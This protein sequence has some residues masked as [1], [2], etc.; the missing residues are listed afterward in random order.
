[1]KLLT[2]PKITEENDDEGNND[3]IDMANELRE[4][5]AKIR[6]ISKK[7]CTEDQQLLLDK[8]SIKDD[9]NK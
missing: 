3:E 5:T 1:M 9:E 4:I 6:E 2:P 8:Y 7:L